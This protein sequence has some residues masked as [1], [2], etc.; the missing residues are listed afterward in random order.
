M[1]KQ[2]KKEEIKDAIN[3]LISILEDMDYYISRIVKE[4]NPDYINTLKE[5]IDE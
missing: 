3:L 4:D 2:E 1:N 5:I